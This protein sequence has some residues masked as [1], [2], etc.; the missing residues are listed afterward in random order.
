MRAPPLS[1]R[2]LGQSVSIMAAYGWHSISSR[3]CD[4][5]ALTMRNGSDFDFRPLLDHPLLHI[6]RLTVLAPGNR[7]CVLAAQDQDVACAKAVASSVDAAAVRNGI[8]EFLLCALDDLAEEWEHLFG[9]VACQPHVDEKG[10]AG[11]GRCELD[12]LNPRW[13]FFGRHDSVGCY[14]AAE[15]WSGQ[16]V[17]LSLS[18]SCDSLIGHNHQVAFS[19]KPVRL[20]LVVGRREAG[21]SGKE[22][23]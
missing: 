23:Q 10:L 2:L 8:C 12:L 7:V 15:P 20:Q 17:L 16:L 4:T 6:L 11:L 22:E 14:V 21:A 5:R 1:R 19:G 13:L 9:S 3:V 18:L